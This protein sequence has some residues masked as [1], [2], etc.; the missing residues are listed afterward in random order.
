[1]VMVA[2]ASVCMFLDIPRVFEE[3][4]QELSRQYVLSSEGREFLL[5]YVSM[6]TRRGFEASEESKPELENIRRQESKLLSSDLDGRFG[7]ALSDLKRFMR[8]FPEG[9]DGKP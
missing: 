2:T 4:V 5:T 6:L 8:T 7:R 9:L 3:K 1:M